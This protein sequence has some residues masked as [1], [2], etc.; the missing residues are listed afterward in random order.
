MRLLTLVRHAKSSW[1]NDAL[2]DFERPLNPRGRRDAPRMAAY[3]R[4][5]VGIPD[6]IITSPALRAIST[7]RIFATTLGIDEHALSIQSRIYEA[8]LNTLVNL[9]SSTDEHLH[10]LMLFGHN[11]GLSELSH[12]LAICPFAQL[13]TC[14]VA[15]FELDIR[16]WAD[17]EPRCGTLRD[18]CSPKQL[19][20]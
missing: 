15:H 3:N 17:L 6:L 20:L 9:L 11:P 16:H 4:D 13:P 2:S 19:K 10:H 18:Y 5:T 12:Y 8:S 14:A 1:D 7:A